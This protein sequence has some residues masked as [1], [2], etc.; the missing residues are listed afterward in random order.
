MKWPKNKSIVNT[1][2]KIHFNQ[3]N[4]FHVKILRNSI[5]NKDFS[6]LYPVVRQACGGAY[7]N[8]LQFIGNDQT[9]LS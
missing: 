2:L 3:F 5:L 7:L 8:L 4:F 1:S 6:S 9:F